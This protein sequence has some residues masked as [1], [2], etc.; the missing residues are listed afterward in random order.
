LTTVG[1]YADVFMRNVKTTLQSTQQE[2][3]ILF[4]RYT[5]DES[6]KSVTRSTEKGW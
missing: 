3:N 4:D 6:I 1:D 2:L 5:A